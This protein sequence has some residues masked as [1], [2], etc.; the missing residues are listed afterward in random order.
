MTVHVK[1]KHSGISKAER[2]EIKHAFH[3]HFPDRRL[4]AIH[5]DGFS[6]E[7]VYDGKKK[8]T[9]ITYVHVSFYCS[10][11]EELHYHPEE[12]WD[13]QREARAFLRDIHRDSHSPYQGNAIEIVFVDPGER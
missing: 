12:E 10:E 2:Q 9:D 3:Q 8:D 6:H 11:A 4:L 1:S 7:V 5:L 13:R